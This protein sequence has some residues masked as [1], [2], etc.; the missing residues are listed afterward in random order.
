[1]FRFLLSF[2]FIFIVNS[3][4][5]THNRAG[6]ITY[7]HISG[8]TYEIKIITCTKTSVDAD[9]EWL[10]I[11]WGDIPTGTIL[12][13]LQR[14][15]IVLFSDF[16]AQRNVYI[17]THTYPG[18]AVYTISVLDPNRNSGVVNILGSVDVPFCI[19]SELIIS[20]EFTPNNS[21]VLL[22]PPKSNACLNELWITN[23]GAYD[24]DGDIL[25]Y[26]LIPCKGIDCLDIP[27]YLFP[28]ES[29]PS[30]TDSFTIDANNGTIIWDVPATSG[31][32]NFAILI[33]EFREINGI[34]IK[35]GHVIRDMQILVETCDNNAPE[36][37]VVLDT[38]ILINEGLN[39]QLEVTDPDGNQVSVN[40]T[41][42]IFTE[43]ENQATF[44]SSNNQFFWNP[45]CEEVRPNAY[46]VVFIA[47]DDSFQPDLQDIAVL[48]I[49]VIAPAVENTGAEVEG[50][51][52]FLTW[53]TN[54]CI[55][56]YS[57]NEYPDFNYKIYRR[58]NEYGYIPSYCETGVP[59]YTGYTLIETVN[60]LDQN[61]YMDNSFINYGNTYCYMVVTCWPNGAESIASEEFC[62]TISSKEAPVITNVSVEITDE[63]TGENYV[64]WSPPSDI[65]TTIFLPPYQ[66]KLYWNN[67][68]VNPNELVYESSTSNF[69]YWQDTTFN[70]IGIDTETD[71]NSYRVEFF[72]DS[73]MISTS[74]FA[75]SD[76]ITLTP[77]DNQ[78]T[79]EVHEQVP[80]VNNEY[81][82]YR[83]TNSIYEIIGVTNTGIFNDT[84]LVN[85]HEYC[86]Y[87]RGIGTYSAPLVIDPIINLSQIACGKPGD[88]TPP[89]APSLT[90]EEDCEE[91]YIIFTWNN[92]NLTC[93][94]DVT[95]YNLYHSDTIGGN[96]TLLT[97]FNS[98]TDTVYIYNENGESTSI[99]GCYYLTALD[100]LIENATGF[101]QNE[102][103]GSEIICIDNCPLYE[104]PNIF[105][106][107]G[108]S[109]N[110]QFIPFPYRHVESID[111]KIFNRW[112]VLV[113]ETKDPDINWNG[114][115]LDSNNLLSD[116]T[117]YYT[118]AVNTIR[119]TGIKTINKSG[120]LQLLG[121]NAEKLN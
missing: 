12:D 78:I 34:E 112:G 75:S 45:D 23:P 96:F 28:A 57:E 106:P 63:N 104:L 93:A 24:P 22:N 29:T 67:G 73:E 47:T 36:I 26:S 80:W 89:C 114:R 55:G 61:S 76:F 88:F 120:Y 107:N 8:T 59:E 62:V 39:I 68:I 108:D 54:I 52:V 44:N 25:K 31:E 60:G 117:Y 56:N 105:T 95:M 87:V 100:S 13:S 81:E 102:S 121:G 46:Q 103:I 70:H 16:D 37:S 53:D 118:I 109:N 38:C 42:G 58:N 14:D 35:V 30:T 18:P 41:G 86:Y 90:S 6:E 72:S 11:N 115:G 20:P 7:R 99:A 97:S 21:V 101:T 82:V 74:T 64:A 71:N 32:Y 51:E 83:L 43:L 77:N 119:L 92:P 50:N 85:H 5:A 17:G 111:L 84:G 27:N 98:P 116:G 10:Q 65:D 40:A 113:F 9:R 91:E 15:S 48:D 49:T 3:S 66:Y 19:E 33:E 94:D 69:L 110:D 1:M 2:F 4:F 79:I